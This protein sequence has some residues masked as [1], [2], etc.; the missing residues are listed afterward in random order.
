M[1]AAL[2]P[3]PGAGPGANDELDD[4]FADLIGEDASND[5]SNQPS[6]DQ[7]DNMDEEIK[8]TKKRKPVAKLDESR[9]VMSLSPV[10]LQ[11]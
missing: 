1:P 2:S 4:L 5:A 7:P 10:E 8:I 6:R 9:C 3:E 11:S